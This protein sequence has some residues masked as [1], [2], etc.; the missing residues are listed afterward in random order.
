MLAGMPNGREW[1]S[2]KVIAIIFH[3]WCHDVRFV[4]DR[5]R[6]IRHMRIVA[7]EHVPGSRALPADHPSVGPQPLRHGAN[8]IQSLNPRG[9]SGSIPVCPC[10]INTQRNSSETV[11]TQ[12][13]VIPIYLAEVVLHPV[14]NRFGFQMNRKRISHETGCAIHILRREWPRILS[15]ELVFKRTFVQSDK[16]IDARQISTHCCLNLSRRIRLE[17]RGCADRGFAHSQ[18][19]Q[20]L[21]VFDHISTQQFRQF[22]RTCPSQQI[23]LPKTLRSMHIAQ[24]MHRI[25]LIF[26]INMRHRHV[27]KNDLYRRR[28]SI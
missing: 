9:Q 10:R 13:Q 16:R 14:Q 6:G 25:A 8:L 18:R 24:C 4:P 28:Y 20:V 7:K 12:R 26:S 15:Q 27:I 1:Q 2:S 21:V 23:H 3:F 19:T 11:L 22:P 5:G 17:R